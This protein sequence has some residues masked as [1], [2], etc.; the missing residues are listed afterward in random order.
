MSGYGAVDPIF[1]GRNTGRYIRYL[2]EGYAYDH[3]DSPDCSKKSQIC[4][5]NPADLNR[6]DIRA[7][8]TCL[9]DE[10]G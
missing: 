3:S 4:V 5:E 7:D 9:G 8:R 2:K 1:I 6:L 10:G